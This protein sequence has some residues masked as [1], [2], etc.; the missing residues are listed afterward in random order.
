MEKKLSEVEDMGF[1][2]LKHIP[3]WFVN[4]KMMVAL[5]KSYDRDTHSLSVGTRKIRI[6]VETVAY[7]FGLPNHVQ[8]FKI[9][10]TDE[11][12]EL[13]ES[14]KIHSQCSLTESV[15]SCTIE[16]DEDRIKFRRHF[17]L[18]ICK[19]FFFPS[20]RPT[21]SEK[22]INAVIDVSDPMKIYW[23]RYIYDDIIKEVEEFQNKGKKT[24]DGCMYALLIIYLMSNLHGD[25]E[26]YSGEEPWVKD[27]TVKVIREKVKE[28]AESP[29]GLLNYILRTPTN[30]NNDS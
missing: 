27:W 9:A 30:N 6:E 12:N 25:L 7:C 15:K 21:I 5:A 20:P 17:I 10:E 24:I 3:K 13:F 16:S 23:A 11:E 18:L 22:H 29:S 4:Q 19:C 1:G 2:F 26:T 28:E 8:S 14:L